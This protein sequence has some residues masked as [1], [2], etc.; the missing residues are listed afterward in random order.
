MSLSTGMTNNTASVGFDFDIW[1]I[2]GGKGTPLPF[3]QSN[4]AS[5]WNQ[6]PSVVVV[7]DGD[8][9][10]ESLKVNGH[11]FLGRMAVYDYLIENTGYYGIHDDD[12]LK[13]L[14]EDDILKTLWGDK[15]EKHFLWGYG[16]ILDWEARSGRLLD[17]K[18]MTT[19]SMVDI[20][21]IPPDPISTNSW[22]AYV[23]FNFCVCILLGAMEAGVVPH[24]KLVLD[25]ESQA[26]VKNDIIVKRAIQWWAEFW[27]GAFTDFS[28]QM[29]ANHTN[30][31][32]HLYDQLYD[33]MNTDEWTVHSKVFQYAVF[34]DAIDC[35]SKE[36]LPL[37]PEPEQ[38]F[39]VGFCRMVDLLAALN[40]RTDLVTTSENGLG[41]LP[42]YVLPKDYDDDIYAGASTVTSAI[43]KKRLKTIENLH[44]FSKM[45]K[46]QIQKVVS[47]FTKLAKWKT[48]RKNI[49]QLL[50]DMTH[51]NVFQ[52]LKGVSKLMLFF[53]LPS[54][55][56]EAAGWLALGSAV[57]I[58]YSRART[59]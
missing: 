40:V 31:N 58:W 9:Q 28:H 34:D 19:Q 18:S 20:N 33:T 16:S 57:G 39:A 32:D 5:Y 37:M 52:K 44:A 54:T 6:I 25:D 56:I 49:S 21:G 22:W 4:F 12:D 29:V 24:H 13:K 43:A 23:N 36:L 45:G 17:P 38:K 1:Q 15:R 41:Y 11:S 59:S 46:P 48:I 14:K 55:A 42:T 47:F 51:G 2:G 7:D 30:I 50:D 27:K 10:T 35:K 8:E 3:E 53:V 26:L